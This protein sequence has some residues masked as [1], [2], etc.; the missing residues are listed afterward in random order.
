M[1]MEMRSGR[2][3]PLPSFCVVRLCKRTVVRGA[4]FEGT[5]FLGSVKSSSDSSSCKESSDKP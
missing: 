4:F 1:E 2:F 3:V 5:S